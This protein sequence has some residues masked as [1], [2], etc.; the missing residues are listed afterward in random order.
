MAIGDLTQIL[1]EDKMDTATVDFN[2]YEVSETG[3]P[4]LT[5]ALDNIKTGSLF[6]VLFSNIKASLVRLKTLAESK[7]DATKVVE[8]LNILQA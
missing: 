7:F 2:D 6:G 1:T 5:T 3:M 8:S 4:D